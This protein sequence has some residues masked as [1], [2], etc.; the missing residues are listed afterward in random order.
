MDWKTDL[1]SHESVSVAN[2]EGSNNTS[3]EISDLDNM[4]YDMKEDNLN[5]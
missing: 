5:S 1:S 3:S 4:D 2:N